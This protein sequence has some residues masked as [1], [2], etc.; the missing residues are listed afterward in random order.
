MA[1]PC[2]STPPGKKGHTPHC[3][4]PCLP[5]PS[6]TLQLPCHLRSSSAMLWSKCPTGIM[7]LKPQ[8]S[9]VVSARRLASPR[10]SLGGSEPACTRE[11]SCPHR[12][13]ANFH[14][15]SPKRRRTSRTLYLPCDPQPHNICAERIIQWLLQNIATQ[16]P[17][18]CCMQL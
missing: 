10:R 14:R 3:V 4:H 6:T 13:S 5:V 17:G 11:G 9:L 8:C 7:S 18:S 12:S 16:R 2:C 1:A 15:N